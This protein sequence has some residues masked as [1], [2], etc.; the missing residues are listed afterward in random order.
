MKVAAIIAE[1]NP[2]HNGHAYQI[3]RLREILGE[4]T[5]VIAIMSGNYTQRAESALFEKFSRARCAVEGGVNLVLELPFPY[6]T[7]SAEFFARAGV[8]IAERLGVVDYLV[9]GSESGELDTLRRAASLAG[10]GGYLDKLE[11]V[12]SGKERGIGYAKACERIAESEL[13]EL[14]ESIFTPNNILGVEYLKALSRL[15][16]KIIPLTI[17]REGADYNSALIEKSEHQSAS[18]IRNRILKGDLSALDYVPHSTKIAISEAQSS[19]KLSDY[20]RLDLPIISFLRL[21]PPT[22]EILFHEAKGGLYNRLCSIAARTNGISHLVDEAYTKRY[23]KARIRRAILN[24]Y[25]G[26]TS[27]DVSTLPEYTQILAMDK[28][29][30]SLLKKIKRVTSTTLLTKPSD[31]K[32]LTAVAKRQ[33][34]LSDKADSVYQLTLSVPNSGDYSITR[35]PF[36]KAE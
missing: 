35:S 15:S 23:T 20:S 8:S 12:L 19:G 16:S 14:T 7:S 18:A 21:N 29:G 27:A 4:D 22:S 9:F 13:G 30:A 2:F 25:L 34:E 33:K 26:V 32:A 28:V 3:R 10:D 17:K 6:S 5:A 24:S 36:I 1:Y 31:T 11:C